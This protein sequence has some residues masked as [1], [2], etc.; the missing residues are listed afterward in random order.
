[1]ATLDQR[2]LRV[3]IEIRGKFHVYEGLPIKASGSKYANEKQN[4][5]EIQIGN[6][7]KDVREY[8]LTELSPFNKNRTP[9]KVFVEAGRRSSGAFLLYTG[10]VT[11]ISVTQ[12]PDIFCVLKCLT[13]DFQK[14]NVVARTAG[15][16]SKLSTIA[17]QVAADLGLVLD[18]QATDKNVANYSHSGA[19]LR[20]V[21]KLAQMGNVAAFVDDGRLVLKNLNAPL[22]GGARVLNVDSGLIGQPEATEQG[23]KVKFLIDG[24]MRLG[25][26]LRLQS[27]SYPSFNGEYTIYKL[28]FDVA[29]RDTPFYYIAEAKRL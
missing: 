9:K 6:L 25:Q 14:G 29:N 11:D 19:A 1:M 22:R 28:D 8:L 27:V 26:G 15:P 21:D 10:E 13:S 23:V 3:G 5:S 2:I 18:F 12:P 16:M 24:E 20:Q 7:S 4:S 17:R